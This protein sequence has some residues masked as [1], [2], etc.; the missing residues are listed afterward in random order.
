MIKRL[1]RDVIFSL[2]E[3]LLN[4]WNS[5]PSSVVSATTVSMFKQRLDEHWTTSGY[6]YTQRPIVPKLYFLVISNLYVYPLIII[7]MKEHM[8]SSML[9]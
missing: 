7:I 2:K 3:L 6:G 8:S 9:L 4:L 5:L 1:I